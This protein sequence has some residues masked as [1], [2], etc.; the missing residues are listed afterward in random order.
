MKDPLHLGAQQELFN[1]IAAQLEGAPIPVV[2]NIAANILINAIRMTTPTR[3]GAENTID[4]VWRRS[5]SLLLDHYDAVTGKRKSVFAYTQMA[6]AP[7]LQN[8]NTVF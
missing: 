6:Q 7:F 5:K 4:E 3:E 8:K 2:H 1:A